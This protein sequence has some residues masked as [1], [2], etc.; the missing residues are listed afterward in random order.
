VYASSFADEETLRA[1]WHQM[2]GRSPLVRTLE[3]VVRL[4]LVLAMA[5]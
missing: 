3:R 5:P 1:L 2:L 4:E